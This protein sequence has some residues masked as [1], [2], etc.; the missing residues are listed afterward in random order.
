M[1]KTK[2]SNSELQSSLSGKTYNFPKYTTQIMNLANSNAQGTRPKV[3]GQMS[4]L[5][6]EF[7]GNNIKEWEEW[8]LEK[9]PEAINNATSKILNMIQ[10]FQNIIG[11]IDENMIKEWVEE[12]VIVKTY[13]GLKFQDAILKKV[14]DETKSAYRLA[15]P[16]EESKGIDGY[17]NDTAISIKPITYKTKNLSENIEVPIIFY[18][19]KK[20]GISIEYNL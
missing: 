7:P 4:D 2:I 3:V 13:S 15:N 1:K 12:L 19:K 17:I 20:D 10:E 6:Q 8:Y 11:S 14:A 18:D 16:E 9:H 5:I